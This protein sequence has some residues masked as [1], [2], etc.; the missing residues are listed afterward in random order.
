[1]KYKNIFVICYTETTT[2]NGVVSVESGVYDFGYAK[3]EEATAKITEIG[4]AIMNEHLDEVDEGKCYRDSISSNSWQL[5]TVN[6]D[7]YEYWV[8]P[9]S[10]PLDFFEQ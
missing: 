7:T 10:I 4:D 2:T 8:K 9:V 6:N 3:E 5:V 1:M